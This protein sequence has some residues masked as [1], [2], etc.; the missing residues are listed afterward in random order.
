MRDLEHQGRALLDAL[1]A[2]PDPAALRAFVREATEAIAG[3]VP[4]SETPTASAPPTVGD[5]VEVVGGSIK[6]ELVEIHGDRARIQRGGL[7]FEV[8]LAQVRVSGEP[9][10]RE[11]IAISVA[12]PIESDHERGEINLVGQRVREGI[13]ALAGFLDR[14]VRL[15]H[16]EVRVV[17]GLGTGALRRAV[18]EFLA[19]SPYCV[20]FRE[21]DGSRGGGGVTI[22]EL[23]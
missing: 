9:E 19:A 7:R 20:K 22:V 4:P 23:G 3:H 16:S 21:E 8:A 1:R 17:H 10:R 5:L 13:D 14:S 15:G 2:K 6:G 12:R 18:Q 11:R